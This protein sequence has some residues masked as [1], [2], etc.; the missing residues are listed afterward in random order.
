MKSGKIGQ[1][2]SEEKTFKDFKHVYSQGAR[3]VPWWQNFDCN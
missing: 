2:V 1:A 3:Q